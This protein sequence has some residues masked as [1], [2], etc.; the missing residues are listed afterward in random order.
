MVTVSAQMI[1]VSPN[2]RWPRTTIG[3]NSTPWAID[4][5]IA[6]TARAVAWK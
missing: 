4:T 2:Q 5:T 6:G 1:P 3:M